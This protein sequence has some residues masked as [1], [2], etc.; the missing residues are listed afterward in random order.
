MKHSHKK[1]NSFPKEKSPLEQITEHLGT[2]DDAAWYAERLDILGR[3]MFPE[4]W[5]SKGTSDEKEQ[6]ND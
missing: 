6:N 5:E 3:L 1:K 4:Q 2:Q